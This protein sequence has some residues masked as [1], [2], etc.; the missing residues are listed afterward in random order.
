MEAVGDKV[1]AR[2]LAAAAGLPVVPSFTKG[3]VPLVKRE[4]E[5]P[6]IVKAA[7][8]GGGRGMRVVESRRGS[9]GRRR[10]GAARGGGRLRRR[11]RLHREVPAEGAAHRGAGD[12]RR[13]A[14]R[15]R[16]L[17]AAAPSEGDR[18]G[19]L[20]GGLRRPA[21]AAVRGG[22]GAG[23][24]RRLRERGHRRVHLRRRRPQRALLPGDERPPAGRA[25][26]DRAR[27]R[28]G[29]GGAP[30]P[31]G[32]EASSGHRRGGGPRSRDRGARHRRGRTVAAADGNRAALR[33][34]EGRAGRRR[35]RG[36][37]AGDRATTTP[38]WRRSSC[39]ARTAP[40]RSAASTARSPRP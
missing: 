26:G 15:A 35:H 34:S 1:R 33:A 27:H 17:A 20:A 31:G 39:T 8:G 36:G 5:F 9:P 37:D 21:R 11:S 28:A 12:R 22:I 6:V 32:G 23:P 18:G 7:A 3:S 2:E 29:P 30:A 40:T 16:V 24:G 38:C 25:S 10:G 19:A 4:L 13:G 14:G